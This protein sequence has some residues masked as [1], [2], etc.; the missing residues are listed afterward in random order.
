MASAQRDIDRRSGLLGLALSLLTPALPAS[1]QNR[2]LTWQ[3]TVAL[4][5]A[6][7]IRQFRQLS[8][9]QM[10]ASPGLYT[11]LVDRK[12][13]PQAFGVDI[14]VLRLVFSQRVFFDTDR[15]ALRP[16]AD[17]ELDLVAEVLRRGAADTAVFIAGHTDSRGS[18]AYNY[19]LSVRRAESVAIALSRRRVPQTNIWRIGFGKAVPL[20]PNTSDADMA[21]NRRVEFII[22]RK[23]EAVARVLADQ[24]ALVCAGAGE[25]QRG[26]CREAALSAL[27]PI[28]A[29]PVRNGQVERVIETMPPV[30]ARDEVVPQIISRDLVAPG[31]PAE[32]VSVGPPGTQTVKIEIPPEARQ[33]VEIKPD[34]PVVIDL[35]ESRVLVERLE[36]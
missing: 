14:P 5:H 17:R 15:D 35:R 26:A 13:L 27:P 11:I 24:R 3:Q 1:G 9:E 2:V 30:S 32:R 25:A 12:D 6:D 22:G 31:R 36:R 33:V 10:I 23:A 18:D 20:V 4:E 16:E 21:R 28:A 34:E 19:F 29:A 8:S 7:R